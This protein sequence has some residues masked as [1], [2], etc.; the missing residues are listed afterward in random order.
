M[1]RV[2]FGASMSV[3]LAGLATAQFTSPQGQLHKVPTT[4]APVTKSVTP[5][6]VARAGAAG[7]S[8]FGG[9]DDC[10]APDVVVGT[11]TFSFD[12]TAATTGI[13][14]QTEILCDAFGTTGIDNDVWFEWTATADGLAVMQ[15]NEKPTINQMFE[16]ETRREKNLEARQKE[17][18]NEAKRAAAR[19]QQDDD[20][21]AATT[22]NGAVMEAE[23]EFLAATGSRTSQSGAGV[24]EDISPLEVPL[25]DE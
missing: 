8:F 15:P 24:F 17:L 4:K 3:A 11:G 21:K 10:T 19:A 6:G 5:P 7:G 1:K 13:D 9:G 23:K 16:R 25:R 18:R 14:G 20:G 22:S 2:L 12:N